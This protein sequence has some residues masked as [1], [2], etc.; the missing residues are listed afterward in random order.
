MEKNKL[1]WRTERRKVSDLIAWEGNPRQMTE[2]QVSD[3]TKSLERF[4][5]VEIPAINTDN[6]VVAGHQR[7]AIM[8][9]IG[10][11]SEEIDVRVPSRPL[12]KAEFKEYNL[13]SNQNHAEFDFEILA[14]QYELS[15][16]LDVGFTEAQLKIVEKP[17]K[18]ICDRCFK[19]VVDLEKICVCNSGNENLKIE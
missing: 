5:L 4:N 16:L 10:R 19:K 12:T 18:K 2:K 13:R 9:A 11:G 3:L 7:L 17:E 14:N 1:E 8:S 6:T 15:D